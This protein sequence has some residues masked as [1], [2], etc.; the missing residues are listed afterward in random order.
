MKT[1]KMFSIAAM[2]LVLVWS[3]CTKD[4]E[5]KVRP[6]VVSTSP[7]NKAVGIATNNEVTATFSVEMNP[8][9]ITNSR[10]TLQQGTTS[11]AGTT[12]YTG[13]TASFIPSADLTPNKEYTAT[14][15]TGVKN[16][17]G[18]GL[19]KNYVWSFTTGAIPDVILPT[20]TLTNPAADATGVALNHQIVT[21]FSEPM[22]PTTLTSLKRL[23]ARLFVAGLSYTPNRH[24]QR[25]ANCGLAFT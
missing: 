25:R 9:T 10:F 3:G 18:T 2:L 23:T 12:A 5:P 4:N 8:E 6:R 1:T 22:N 21:T 16:M 14:I 24:H 11:V 7:V 17:E 13:T 20:V 19:A 15:T